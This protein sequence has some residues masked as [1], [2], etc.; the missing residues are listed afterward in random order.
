MAGRLGMTGS[1]VARGD[2]TIAKSFV[3]GQG[4]VSASR[5]GKKALRRAAKDRAVSPVPGRGLPLHQRGESASLTPDNVGLGALRRT[6]TTPSG[7]KNLSFAADF[8]AAQRKSVEDAM[9]K[10]IRRP[11]TFHNAKPHLG[12]GVSGLTVGRTGSK[13]P[14]HVL[15]QPGAS[16]AVS[17]HEFEHSQ[18]RRKYHRVVDLQQDP[19]KQGAE[20]GRADARMIRA[21][22]RNEK[23]ASDYEAQ[24][25]LHERGR[26]GNHEARNAF[27]EVGGNRDR[28]AGYD[29]I[30]RRL[31]VP[32]RD[33]NALPD[34]PVMDRIKAGEPR[35]VRKLDTSMTDAEAKRLASRYDTRGPLPKTLSREQRMKAYEGRYVAAGGK[36]AEKWKRRADRAETARNIGLAGA[37]ASGAAILA[38]KAPGLRRIKPHRLETVAVASGVGGGTAELYGEHARSRRAS[39]QNS[40][41]GVA[42]SALS[43]MR[44]YTP[45]GN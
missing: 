36:K 23:V 6:P 8:P 40:P 41:A 1:G 28:V 33:L 22:G 25:I 21:R 15:V 27:T 39:Y 17:R 35:R 19:V 43:R 12:P 37:T 14:A 10:K 32:N 7:K 29:S 38:R 16:P 42:A 18:P 4:Y 45:G 34:S 13:R 31:G 3:P 11:V 9:P 30:R 24:S 5:T 26:A 2:G 20:E 44:A